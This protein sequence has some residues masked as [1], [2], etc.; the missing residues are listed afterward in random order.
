MW[1]R[2]SSAHSH[3]R[4]D[5]PGARRTDG[6]SYQYGHAYGNEYGD[7]GTDSDTHPNLHSRPDGNLYCIAN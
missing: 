1:G 7:G 4:S 2:D 3:A 5:S 6:G